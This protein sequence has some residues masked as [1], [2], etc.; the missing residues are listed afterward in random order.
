MRQLDR[1]GRCS[2]RAGLSHQSVQIDLLI[3]A[4]FSS[5][6]NESDTSTTRKASTS[7]YVFFFT[8]SAGTVGGREQDRQVLRRFL[9]NAALIFFAHCRVLYVFRGMS[10][11]AA[12]HTESYTLPSSPNSDR[13]RYEYFVTSRSRDMPHTGCRYSAL[14]CYKRCCGGYGK[15]CPVASQQL[16]TSYTA[17]RFQRRH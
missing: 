7:R 9:R 17:A 1:G 5:V 12:L 4:K 3:S 14:A 10:L 6:R 2:S 8:I 16:Y 15:C 13:V 11:R